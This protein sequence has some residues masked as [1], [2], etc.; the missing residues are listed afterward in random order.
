MLFE[1]GI[2]FEYIAYL[3]I[4]HNINR[5]YNLLTKDEVLGLMIV[6]LALNPLSLEGKIFFL[7]PDLDSGN[8]F[9][10]ITDA[11][12]VIAANTIDL[13]D[14]AANGIFIGAHREIHEVML[15]TRSWMDLYYFQPFKNL[16]MFLLII[17]KINY[18]I[19]CNLL[20]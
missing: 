20:L 10:R 7:T 14:E 9:V 19:Y 5:N 17:D 2:N 11:R 1:L 4:Y 16:S 18:S 15:Y 12:V 8:R 3:I 13:P 6:C